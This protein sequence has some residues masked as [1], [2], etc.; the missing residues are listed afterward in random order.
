ML[1]DIFSNSYFS[2]F[3]TTA[4]TLGFTAYFLAKNPDKQR[5]LIEE[6]D[7]ICQDEVEYQGITLRDANNLII[8]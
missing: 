5:I 1:D 8:F 4:N 7:E 3:D 6:I 2:R